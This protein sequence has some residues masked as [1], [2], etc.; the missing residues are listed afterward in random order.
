MAFIEIKEEKAQRQKKLAEQIAQSQETLRDQSKGKATDASLERQI[1]FSDNNLGNTLLR[2]TNPISV[3]D[4]NPA[5]GRN[6][7]S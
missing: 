1:E 5:Y 6:I 4:G 3:N 7:V 2:K